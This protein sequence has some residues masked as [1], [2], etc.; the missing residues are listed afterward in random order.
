MDYKQ[1]LAKYIQHVGDEE[2]TDFIDNC[3]YNE[4]FT[5]EEIDALID[6]VGNAECKA[7]LI[8]RRDSYREW[9]AEGRP[10]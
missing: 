6:L 3:H 10:D 1:L 8:Q 2:G 7:G 4:T 5:Y 9:V